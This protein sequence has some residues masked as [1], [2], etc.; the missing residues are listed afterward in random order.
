MRTELAIGSSKPSWMRQERGSSR[1]EK[2]P[3]RGRNLQK[4]ETNRDLY[5]KNDLAP[6][7]YTVFGELGGTPPGGVQLVPRPAKAIRN[8]MSKAS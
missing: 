6:H 5:D 2:F 4:F 8:R 1:K 7:P 3:D